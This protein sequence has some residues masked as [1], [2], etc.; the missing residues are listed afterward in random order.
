MSQRITP[1]NGVVYS[2]TLF[3]TTAIY[4]LFTLVGTIRIIAAEPYGGSGSSN[5]N[6]NGGISVGS[7]SSSSI[8]IHIPGGSGISS[9]SNSNFGAIGFGG[10]GI[11]NNNNGNSQSRISS[12]NDI[13]CPRIC[14]CNGQTIDCSHRGLTQVPRKLPIDAER[15]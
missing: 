8:G 14:N 11:G 1:L 12:S 9:N 5:S 2:T 4:L 3:I 6:N 15:M 13:K 10:I 7:I